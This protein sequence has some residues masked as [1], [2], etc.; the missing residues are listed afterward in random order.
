MTITLIAWPCL[1][2]C[3]SQSFDRLSIHAAH[4]VYSCTAARIWGGERVLKAP[5]A[6]ELM[7]RGHGPLPPWLSPSAYPQTC[8]HPS[9]RQFRAPVSV[10]VVW[11]EAFD[12][13]SPWIT[14]G[15][16]AY[17]VSLTHPTGSIPPL[18]SPMT[19]GLLEQSGLVACRLPALQARPSAALWPAAPHSDRGLPGQR[20]AAPE[21]HA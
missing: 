18:P 15:P 12:L 5:S 16:T 8:F 4:R 10:V 1:P 14:K 21:L 9:V 17:G 13:L 6:V 19:R 11:Q 20:Q 7:V 3:W 2:L